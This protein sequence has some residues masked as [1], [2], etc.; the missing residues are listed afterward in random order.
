MKKIPLFFLL[1]ASAGFAADAPRKIAFE[2]DDD[3]VWVANLDGSGA[4]KIARSAVDPDISPDGTKVAFN[5]EDKSPAR[6]IA[7]ADL[8]TGKTTLFKDVPSDNCF[9]PVWAPDGAKLLFYILLDS[10]WD[11][12]LV[13]ADGSGFRI[14]KKGGSGSHSYFSACW[15]PDGQSLYCQDL[16]NLYHIGLDGAVIQQWPLQK[17]F[18][19]GDMDS[20][21]RFDVSPDGGTLLVEL[22]SGADPGRKDWDGPAPS[23]W[24]MDLATQTTKNLTPIF[25]W[26]PCWLTASEFLCISEGPK[27]KQP[28]IYRRTLD[29]KTRNLLIKNATD[30]SVSK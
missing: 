7:V 26:E 28:S 24:A 23:I 20:N 16:E 11:I 19:A 21:M 5:T 12:G 1:L 9:G 15:M 22:N 18:A 6:R 3:T 17:L 29:G 13:N 14:L 8:A 2:R 10:A 25:W 27:E 30:P 4:K